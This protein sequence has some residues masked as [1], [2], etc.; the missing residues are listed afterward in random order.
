[1]PTLDS[2][3][4][5]IVED[6]DDIAA[7]V[8]RTLTQA[9]IG[10][11]RAATGLDGLWMARETTYGAL[12]LD[13]LLPGM[14]GYEV[15]RTLRSEGHAVPILMLTAKTGEYDET[16]GFEMGADDYLR[17]PFSP[18]VLTARIKS[19]L[20]RSGTP[21]ASTELE[22]GGLQFNVDTRRCLLDDTPVTLTPKEASLL[23]ALLRNGETP[24]SRD[25]L[26]TEVWG[27]EFDGNTNVVDVYIGYLRKKLGKTRIENVRGAGYRVAS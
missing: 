21:Q 6:D 26:L 4:V 24:L 1:M 25:L 20:R 15:C 14:N 5:L 19:L 27:M 12:C 23:E 11:D 22:R 3:R 2:S 10:S 18:A 16:D 13:I 7:L 8:Q 17:K 9:G